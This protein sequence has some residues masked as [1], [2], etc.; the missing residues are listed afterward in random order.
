VVTSIVL[1]GPSLPLEVP[2]LQAC[3]FIYA[4][5]S[6][7]HLYRSGSL[8][9]LFGDGCAWDWLSLWEY[10]VLSRSSIVEILM[11]LMAERVPNVTSSTRCLCGLYNGTE[12]NK[13][14]AS[15]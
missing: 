15:E 14:K 13:P 7:L 8:K 10:S 9:L 6:L 4:Y 11:K 12:C 2:V 5:C 3:S 1:T